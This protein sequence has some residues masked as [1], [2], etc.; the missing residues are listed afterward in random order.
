LPRAERVAVFAADDRAAQ[1]CWGSLPDGEVVFEAGGVEVAVEGGSRPGAVELAGLPPGAALELTM[2]ARADG[3]RRRRRVA[4]FRTLTPPPGRLLGRFATVN[5]VHIGVKGFGFVR[6]MTERDVEVPHAV[7]C[8]RAAITEARRWGAAALVV[9]GDITHAGRPWEWEVAGQELAR[10]GVPVVAVPGNHDVVRRATDGTPI[11][12]RHGIRLVD[13]VA[14]VEL[15]GIA[16]VLVNT[17]ARGA[18]AG[19]MPP[20]RRQAVADHVAAAGGPVFLAMHHYP[21]RFRLP[22]MWPPGIPGPDAVALLDAVAGANPATLVT[23]GHSHRHRAHNHGPLTVAEIGSTKDF[24]GAWAGYAVYEG[25]IMQVVRRVAEPS[26]I[27]W[28]DRTRWAVGGIWGLWSP[29]FRDHRCFT[30]LWP[31]T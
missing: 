2:R 18:E 14:S 19:V 22:T 21:Q 27:A 7:R 24:P 17:T 31:R 1:V 26:A 28:T 9:K 4:H 11:L 16:G 30:H 25:G 8:L 5:D 20:R 3:S 23:S 6:E 12:Q 29:G 15:P 10:A 13:D